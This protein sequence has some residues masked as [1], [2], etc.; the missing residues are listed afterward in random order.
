MSDSE[1]IDSDSEKVKFKKCKRM[2]SYRQE[3]ENS[4]PFL[5]KVDTNVHKAFCNVC[6]KSF[7]ISHGGLNDVKRHVSVPEHQRG[8]R[9]RK[10]TQT[11]QQF[12]KRDV[13]TTDEEKV[14]A[15]E[16]TKV[17]HG[18]NHNM[19]YNSIDCDSKLC[20]V[21]F[22]DSK[23]ASKISLGRTKASSLIYN[24][25]AP[26]SIEDTV[27]K[28]RSG[29]F[30]SISTD[31]SNHGHI[32]LFPIIV[33][34][35]SPENGIGTCL[36]D[37]YEDPD[38]KAIDIYNNIKNRLKALDVDLT[39]VSAYSADNANINFGKNNS[40]YKL[41]SQDNAN[42][43][44][45]G[46]SAH[47]VHNVVRHA[48]EKCEFD[49]ENLV[50]K[51]Y[52][53]LSYHAQRVQ[54]LKQHFADAEIEY[55]NIIRH[56]KTRWLSLH[57]AIGKILRG[58][59]ALKSYFITLGD[60]CPVVLGKYFDDNHAKKTEC[61]LAFL[62]NA[63]K[64]FQNA[65]M[66]LEKDN[67]LSCETYN[68]L[69]DLRLKIEQR[70][71]D[72]FFGF[73]CSNALTSFTIDEQESIKIILIT[74]YKNALKYLDDHF[75]FSEDNNLAIMRI[76]ALENTFIYKDLSMCCEKLSLTKLIDMDELYNEF[77]SVK[78]TVN[79]ITEERKQT[80]PSNEKKSIYE[81]WHELF[82]HSNIPNLLKIFQFIVSIPC[83]N[84]AAERAF[85]LCGNAWTDSRNRLSVE[86]VK[87][88]LQVKIN[89]QYNCKDFYDYV[90]KNK[91]LLKCAKSQD[92][93]SFKKKN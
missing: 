41:L 87:A 88:E 54:T 14:I 58:F 52:G 6:M 15:A 46:C 78:E 65:I 67:A 29:V 38:E 75:D 20:P 39:N 27:E 40:V 26:A 37:F 63:L 4:Y 56:V 45:A 79:K 76:F 83:S 31:A 64:I 72:T 3:W 43:L 13:L 69:T 82:Q 9:A 86:H 10:S 89:F 24:V 47:M 59:P 22:N 61:F 70:M 28:L 42:I 18:V 36:L 33:R 80:P 32:K 77:C 71:N 19:S 93:Y 1:T 62:D 49:V 8:E 35:Y 50:L 57:P 7:M 44:P 21:I 84:A 51:V 66:F 23:I 60:N 25:L 55:Q 85:S 11:L 16:L 92:K 73:N 53:H 2:C 74:W 5:K 91:K 81:A 90:L 34:F 68:I 12:L 30:Y 48:M 17:Y